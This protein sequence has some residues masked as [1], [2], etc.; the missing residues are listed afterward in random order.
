MAERVGSY[1]DLKNGMETFLGRS[2]DWGA[3]GGRRLDST[4]GSRQ[5]KSEREV[6]TVGVNWQRTKAV[7]KFET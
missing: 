1:G 2:W 7:I 4:E 6:A 5:E 3:E